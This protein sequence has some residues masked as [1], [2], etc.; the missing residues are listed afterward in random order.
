MILN[1]SL[2]NSASNST[3]IKLNIKLNNVELENCLFLN[4]TEINLQYKINIHSIN[5]LV[6]TNLNKIGFFKPALIL[7]NLHIQQLDGQ[8]VHLM[9]EKSIY[10]LI[11]SGPINFNLS[12][13]MLKNSFDQNFRPIN[14][15]FI[16]EFLE[17]KRFEIIQLDGSYE[18]TMI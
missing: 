7:S 5:T 16:Y 12:D 18:F 8:I 4:N 10:T 15:N 9:N 17:F 14:K 3:S 2:R 11:K 1:F 6:F 13:E